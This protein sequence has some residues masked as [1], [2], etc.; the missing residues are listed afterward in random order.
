M[1][2]PTI[3]R[4]FFPGIGSPLVVNLLLLSYVVEADSVHMHA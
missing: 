1:G 2:S 3:T 4:S